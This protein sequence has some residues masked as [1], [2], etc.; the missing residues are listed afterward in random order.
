VKKLV[1]FGAGKIGRTFIGQ[2][3][4]TSGFEVVFIDIFELTDLI[5]DL[6]SRFENQAL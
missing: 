4:A 6:L 5:D 2:L 3:F 1:L